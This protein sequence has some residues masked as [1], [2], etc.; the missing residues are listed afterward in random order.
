M[1]TLRPATA[2][3]APLLRHWDEQPHVLAADPNDDWLESNT[4]AHRFYECL[5][6]KFVERRRFGSE[7]C[8]VYRLERDDW[9]REQSVP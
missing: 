5:G 4:R 6:F 1:I 9:A 7:D 3:D 8:V 2:D